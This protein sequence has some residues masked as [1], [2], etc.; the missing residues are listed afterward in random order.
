[1]TSQETPQ[2]IPFN[3]H[4]MKWLNIWKFWL[5]NILILMSLTAIFFGATNF[6]V[7]KGLIIA[8]RSRLIKIRPLTFG[9]F[10]LCTSSTTPIFPQLQFHPFFPCTRF[11]DITNLETNDWAYL[12]LGIVFL[13]SVTWTFSAASTISRRTLTDEY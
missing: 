13:E 5:S 7:N 8:L 9:N 2:S 4:Q 3:S 10:T 6:Q 12:Q 11:T 1:M